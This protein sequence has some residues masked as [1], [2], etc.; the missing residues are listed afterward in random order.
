MKSRTWW[1]L[2]ASLLSGLGGCGLSMRDKTACATTKDCLGGYVCID[3]QCIG[4]DKAPADGGSSPSK[5]AG[6]SDA[7]SRDSGPQSVT[8]AGQDAGQLP[9]GTVLR[10]SHARHQ[11]WELPMGATWNAAFPELYDALPA[12]DDMV[13]R[14]GQAEIWV[15]EGRYAPTV[16]DKSASF[17]LKNNVAIYGGF[18]GTETSRTERDWHAHLSVLSGDLN[19]DDGDT[20]GLSGDLTK[21][22][23]N[24]YLVVQGGTGRNPVD[25]SGVLDGFVIEGGSNQSP[26]NT[27]GGAIALDHG[28][29]TLQHI[30]IAY[31][32][33]P[34]VCTG[35]G[36]PRL[37]DVVIAASYGN[38]L[39]LGNCTPSL[40]RLVIAGNS[41]G[42]SGGTVS[43]TQPYAL[44]NSI[45]A[46]NANGRYAE[47]YLGTGTSPSIDHL[48]VAGNSSGADTANPPSGVM[49]GLAMLD[50]APGPKLIVTNSITWANLPDNG[51][52]DVASWAH[53]CTQGQ[54]ANGSNVDCSTKSPF[55][56]YTALSGTWTATYTYDDNAVQTVL[57]DNAAHFAPGALAGL[58]V[59]LGPDPSA[60]PSPMW[61]SLSW[62]Y[63]VSNTDQDVRVWG[64]LGAWKGDAYTIRDLRPA[65]DA[66]TID[67]AA[68]GGIATDILGQSR[69]D[70]PATTGDVST[71]DIG[72]Y[73]YVPGGP[74]I[75]LAKC[76]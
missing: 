46:G 12:A 15:A 67:H 18:A 51:T 72:A 36:T 65:A 42:S 26:T 16:S 49:N 17:V 22:K 13:A 38:S 45:I 31:S 3:K 55:R 76:P 6:I 10:V 34:F 63:I 37:E 74:A 52:T 19:Y 44:T 14:C 57:H 43:G 2:V 70:V 4:G 64:L 69:V 21:F 28:S 71:A 68:V 75:C 25:A 33:N 24:S 30:V 58:F 7:G 40:D 41:Y 54:G 61:G 9:C 27:T 8:D 62:G 5:D 56:A 48:I 53:S 20:S 11:V 47:F 50:P 23:D 39:Q 29:P 60:W 59:Q 1:L 66:V 35:H 73:E 32:T